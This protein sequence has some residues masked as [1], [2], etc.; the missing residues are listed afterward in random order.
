MLYKNASTKTDCNTFFR[1][2][3]PQTKK[4]RCACKLLTE[5]M[6][7][8]N[9]PNGNGVANKQRK[10]CSNTDGNP[11]AHKKTYTVCLKIREN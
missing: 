10:A 5:N 11:P 3:I 8:P 6:Q 4:T 9:L 7:L 2:K 1:L